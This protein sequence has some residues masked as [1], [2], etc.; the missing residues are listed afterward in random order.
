VTPVVIAAAMAKPAAVLRRPVRSDGAFD[1]HTE[2][3]TDVVEKNDW[4]KRRP[5][6]RKPEAERR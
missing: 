2:L 1:E 5:Q 3:P 6:V 4:Y